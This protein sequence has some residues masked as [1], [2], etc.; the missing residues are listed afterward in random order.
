MAELVDASD[1]KSEAGYTACR[2]NSG[3]PHQASPYGLRLAQPCGDRRAEPARRS[4]SETKTKTGC[5]SMHYTYIIRSLDHPKQIYIGATADLKQRLADHNTGK[6]PHTS[7]F[8]PWKLECYV[9]FPDKQQ[10]Y[11]FENYLKSHSGRAFASR[12]LFSI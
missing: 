4:L 7:K 10:A 1:L 9:G 11:D 2:F 3:C 12:R 8:A 6:S 5:Y